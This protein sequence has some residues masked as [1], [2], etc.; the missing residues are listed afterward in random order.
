MCHVKVSLCTFLFPCLSVCLSVCPSI[1][2]SVCL[3]RFLFRW[4]LQRKR[5]QIH[6]RTVKKR[7]KRGQQGHVPPN[8]NWGGTMPPTLVRLKCCI[9]LGYK[10]SWVFPPAASYRRQ[11]APNSFC[12]RPGPCY[13]SSQLHNAP[14]TTSR[15]ARGL[16]LPIPLPY[17][18]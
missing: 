16:Q 1:R 18:T 7:G 12:N 11:N 6:T 3:S 14:Q 10:I 5:K 15:M 9:I 4:P 13:G 17:A 2:P 8:F